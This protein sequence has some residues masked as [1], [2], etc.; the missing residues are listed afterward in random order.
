MQAVTLKLS[1]LTSGSKTIHRVVTVLALLSVMML[2]GGIALAAR[3]DSFHYDIPAFGSKTYPQW[4]MTD[5]VAIQVKFDVLPSLTWV[6]A[7]D[8]N[9]VDLGRYVDFGAPGV[10]KPITGVQ[11]NGKC[12]RLNMNADTPSPIHV[13]GWVWH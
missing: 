1:L 5:T 3:A 2:S 4:F 13:D 10:W 6:K 11:P 8:C 7:V 12:F 9:L